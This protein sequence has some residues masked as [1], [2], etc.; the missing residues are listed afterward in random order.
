MR[1][2]PAANSYVKGRTWASR[3]GQRRAK[4][5]VVNKT[6]RLKNVLNS[7]LGLSSP[8]TVAIRFDFLW[9]SHIEILSK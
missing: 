9:K 2:A 5:H 7:K 8:A 4:S 1:V 6:F 3:I